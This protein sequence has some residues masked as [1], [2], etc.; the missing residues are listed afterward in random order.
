MLLDKLQFVESICL[1][2]EHSSLK[3]CSFIKSAVDNFSM[4]APRFF[5]KERGGLLNQV[6]GE[7]LP[8]RSLV[9]ESKNALF[10]L[11]KPDFLGY[12]VK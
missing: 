10:E 2:A 11:Y 3:H 7:S 5:Y 6:C 8:G 9:R 12:M 1:V 4:E